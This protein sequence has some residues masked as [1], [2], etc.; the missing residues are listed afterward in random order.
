MGS[1]APPLI[2]CY[3]LTWEKTAEEAGNYCKSMTETIGLQVN[4]AGIRVGIW[5]KSIN[6]I[7]TYFLFNHSLHATSVDVY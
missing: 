3:K 6:L 5:Y 1:E 4:L 2:S 7:P